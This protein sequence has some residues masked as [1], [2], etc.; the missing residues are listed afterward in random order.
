MSALH[1]AS[2]PADMDLPGYHFHEL[3]GRRKGT[4][5]VRVT[6]NWRITFEW[7]GTDATHIDYEDYH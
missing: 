6:G 7:E 2:Q 5:S 1:A 3:G 4:Y